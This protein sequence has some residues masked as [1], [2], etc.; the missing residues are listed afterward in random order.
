MRVRQLLY[1]GLVIGAGACAE[2]LDTE[3]IVPVRG[4]LGQEIFTI[5]HSDMQREDSRRANGFLEAR[6][7]FVAGIDHLFTPDELLYTQD[8]LVRL[9]PLYDDATLPASTQAMA[10]ALERLLQDEAALDSLTALI[11]RKGYVQ[12]SHEAALLRRI[13][14]YPAYQDLVHAVI[15][16]AKGHDGLD[17]TGAL[18]PEE[19]AELRTLQALLS[20]R[21]VELEI[22]EAA[23]RDIV[24]L[25]DLL[26]SEDPRYAGTHGP[27]EIVRRDPRGLARVNY[28]GPAP[29]GP[30]V[31][32]APQDGLADVDFLGRFLDEA[33][34][35]IDL[36]P[37]G[38]GASRDAMGRLIEG[39][40]EVYDYADLDRTLLANMLRDG[41]Y[42]I[43]QEVPMKAVRTFDEVLGAR[44]DDGTYEAFDNPLLDLLYATSQSVD[45]TTVPEQLELL[46]ALL[47]DHES[48]LGWTL[49]ELQAQFD[50]ADR[51]PGGLKANSGLLE[52]LL[53][54]VR[55]VIR[56]QGLPEDLLE[57]LQEDA[58]ANIDDATVRLAQDKKALITE[59]NFDAN[60]VFGTG[61]DRSQADVTGNQSIMQRLLHLIEDTKGAQYEPDLIGIPL[62][63][64]FEI[65]DLAEFYMLS[66]IGE[67]HVPGL[68][69][70]LTGLSGTPS[71]TELARF[72]NTEQT[73]G[74]PVGNEGFDVKDNDGDTL[75]AV[76]ASGM[77]EALRPLVQMFHDRGQLDLL[78]EL[79]HILH[80]HWATEASDYQDA[81]AAQPRYSKLSGIARFEPM[82]IES[83]TEAKVLDAT[84]K[85]L[86]ETETVRTG[87][88]R[89]AHG[90]LIGAAR[91][92]MTKNTGLRTRD[93]ESSVRLDGQRITPLSPIDLLRDG[94]TRLD[95]RINRR[96]RTRQDWDEILDV[97]IDRFAGIERTGPEAG[98]LENPTAMPVL[99]HVLNFAHE[100]AS[101]HALAGDL[102]QWVQ[103]DM[104]GFAEDALTSKELPAL[105]DVIYAID[106][107]EAVSPALIDLRDE[108]LDED[109]GFVDLL[110]TLGDGI[111]A[112]K[113][114]S[115]AVPL[116]KWAGAEL[117]PERG[118]LFKVLDL[119]QRSLA[120]DPDEHFIEVARRGL[121]EDPDT[122]DLYIFGLTAAIR[123][124]N[125][126]DPLSTELMGPNDVTKVVRTIQ[127]YLIDE[128]HGIEKF[129]D[130]VRGRKLESRP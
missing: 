3:R 59:A 114:A 126:V 87:S 81:S 36:P 6:A 30:F 116:L 28:L 23:E 10:G 8:F 54:W 31:D 128:E 62:G 80:T 47:K 11:Q 115:L 19:P 129:Y 130:L 13:A 53:T 24:L 79:L 89:T 73:F 76:S 67:S 84:R 101:A 104:L 4:T 98:R 118:H 88:G 71:A 123:Q 68:V 77:E 72:I 50:I 49:L 46:Q 34:R 85:L 90:L 83:F 15:E 5:F 92:V 122:H 112:A 70:T 97:L 111:E 38:T 82:L 44:T 96:A 64:I 99:L 55:K 103:E 37:F 56:V 106:G 25:A 12:Q 121:E 39:G 74:N 43:E 95:A 61:V 51:H 102:T 48:A 119:T 7:P 27:V 22:S 108:L 41:R 58:L 9:L 109:R 78:F 124:A 93:G 100:R 26:L 20:T 107:N 69:T 113:D 45:P 18:D 1:L 91:S 117:N 42:L 75:F 35:K 17:A 14:A 40:V 57:A 105:F 120:V 32:E 65:D 16:L 21:L 127:N 52:D 29:L 110:V 125:R 86:M 66:M 63:F 2:P 60:Q 33:G 94:L